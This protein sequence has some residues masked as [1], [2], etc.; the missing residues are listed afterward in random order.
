MDYY[1]IM[2][3]NVVEKY[4]LLMKK[5]VLFWLNI[6]WYFEEFC[7]VKCERCRVERLWCKIR[8]EVYR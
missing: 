8:L 2:I 3:Y 7:D 4:V 1:N 5:F 6:K